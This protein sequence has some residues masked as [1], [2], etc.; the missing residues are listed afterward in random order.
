MYGDADSDCGDSP[1]CE[2]FMANRKWVEPR[3]MLRSNLAA[4][5][6]AA[7]KTKKAVAVAKG[8]AKA[9][10]TLRRLQAHRMLLQAHRPQ[11]LA[12][13]DHVA[14]PSEQTLC[15][16]GKNPLHIYRDDWFDQQRAKGIRRP[17][18]TSMWDD[19]KRDFN[20]LTADQRRQYDE[21]SATSMTVA[22]HN[23][24][25]AAAAVAAVAFL[26]KAVAKGK[27]KVAR[28]LR[29]LP[30]GDRKDRE[31]LLSVKGSI[32]KPVPADETLEE[33]L[34]RI[35]L[36]APV[37]MAASFPDPLPSRV[38]AVPCQPRRFYLRRGVELRKHGFTE[39]CF[40]C[41]LAQAAT[42]PAQ[43][44]SEQCRNRIGEAMKRDRDDAVRVEESDRRRQ[45]MTE[46]KYEPVLDVAVRR[47]RDDGDRRSSWTK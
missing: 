9:A 2:I 1:D 46:V 40:G 8:K 10:R 39:A 33:A 11:I 27:A 28:T 3:K 38:S 25:V 34:A 16:V 26:T 29:R 19:I 32:W 24:N 36:P 14:Q 7:A 45:K 44:H 30:E 43:S 23:R 17:W 35:F 41:V 42:T 15:L 20:A 37:V 5:L 47:G 6:R 31:L 12:I 4:A 13:A 18:L 21:R 22:R